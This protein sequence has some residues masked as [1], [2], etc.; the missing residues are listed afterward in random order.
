MR[1]AVCSV[2]VGAHYA[3]AVGRLDASLDAVGFTGERALWRGSYPKRCPS[4]QAV[5]YAFKPWS[6]FLCQLADVDIALW[7]DSICVATRPLDT[8]IRYTEEHGVYFN[9]PD[10]STGMWTNDRCLDAFG[11]SRDDAMGIPMILAGAMGLDLRT[12]KARTFLR[13][14]L[15]AADAGL[16][17]GH[18]QN[19]DGTESADPR[20]LGHRHDQSVA[21]LLI[22]EMRLPMTQRFF[23]FANDVSGEPT[24]VAHGWP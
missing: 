1:V 14:W 22:H 11:V 9:G 6:L 23:R 7:A 12:A 24:W 16:F 5:P 2:G 10:H 20:C 19:A 21:S 4:H 17:H 3:D 15:A 18:H 8:L 13:R